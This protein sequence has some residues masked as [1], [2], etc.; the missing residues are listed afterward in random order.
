MPRPGGK[1]CTFA[2]RTT[3][4]AA[5]PRSCKTCCGGALRESATHTHPMQQRGGSVLLIT[6]LRVVQMLCCMCDLPRTRRKL[7]RMQGPPCVRRR[8]PNSQ[9]SAKRKR[10]KKR[11]LLMRAGKRDV[12]LVCAAGFNMTACL[13][14][15]CLPRDHVTGCR[16]ICE[17]AQLPA[18]RIG[19]YGTWRN[20]IAQRSYLALVRDSCYATHTR[21]HAVSSR[22]RKVL[23]VQETDGGNG[24]MQSGSDPRRPLLPVKSCL[25]AADR[26]IYR[27][28][29]RM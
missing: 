5:T 18:C 4:A 26:A 17:A 24:G 28:E 7:P 19:G 3:T 8:H 21:T 29:C 22:P 9:Q 10:I 23:G 12:A 6:K 11:Y 15:S 20:K 13:P 16:Q 2:S 14:S 25:W 1:L 27:M